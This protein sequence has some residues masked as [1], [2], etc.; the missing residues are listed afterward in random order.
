MWPITFRNARLIKNLFPEPYPACLTFKIFKIFAGKVYIF[1]LYY[2]IFDIVQ[3]GQVINN[4]RIISNG[5]G[6][7]ILFNKVKTKKK[8]HIA[9]EKLIEVIRDEGLQV[10]DKLPPERVISEEMGVSRNT[11]REAI[12]ALQVIGLLETRHSQGNF[13]INT[14]NQNNFETLIALVFKN[15]EDPFSLIDARIAF[16][17]GA[18]VLSTQVCTDKDIKDLEVHFEQIRQA[19]LED[20]IKTYRSEDH[21]L[22]LS[23]AQNTRNIHIVNTVSSL[24]NAMD[25]PLFQSMKD[26]LPDT[27]LRDARIKEHEKIIFAIKYRDEEQVFEALKTH[28]KKSKER[29]LINGNI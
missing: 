4:N 15:D 24:V 14:V 17:P 7:T 21:L 18:A 2:Y 19:L 26:S 10:G 28:L 23:I 1:K 9:A 20:N 3:K 16:E 12:A 5:F 22:H 29:F 8:S 13:I 27:D 25:Q 6:G 11:I